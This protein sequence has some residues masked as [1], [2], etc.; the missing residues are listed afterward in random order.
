MPT[1][2]SLGHILLSFRVMLEGL[3]EQLTEKYTQSHSVIVYDVHSHSY[4]FRCKHPAIIDVS[5]TC[6]NDVGSGFSFT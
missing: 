1:M 6:T 3:L 4:A 2:N 5:Q